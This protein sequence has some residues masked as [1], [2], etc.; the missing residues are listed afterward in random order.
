MSARKPGNGGE[1]FLLA[2][3]K[4][5]NHIETEYGCLVDVESHPT[6]R[7][8]VYCFHLTASGPVV[9]V[10]LLAKI[11][12]IK[13]EYPNATAGTMEGY[14]FNLMMK[15]GQMVAEFRNVERARHSN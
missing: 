4:E 8:G 10:S 13:G 11:A 1:E 5:H 9:D 6:H 3:W 2:L 7:A 14:L 12:T 15:L